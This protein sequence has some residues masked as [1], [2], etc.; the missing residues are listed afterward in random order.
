MVTDKEL[1]KLIKYKLGIF[2]LSKPISEE[3][4]KRV[5]ELSVNN[6][7]FSGQK[8]N[9]DLTQIG[10]L[11]GLQKLDIVSFDIG[12]EEAKSISSL[13]LLEELTINKSSLNV[14]ISMQPLEYLSVTDSQVADLGYL[15]KAEILDLYGLDT[16]D[17]SQLEH[18]KG[19]LKDIG[20]YGGNVKKAGALK[21]MPKL[22][23][24]TFI[25]ATLDDK[26][27]PDE[28][29]DKG[30]NVDYEPDERNIDT[31]FKQ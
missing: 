2:D 25:G 17:L 27:V 23:E 7:S 10:E 4:L 1:L 19:V 11:H 5:Y 20:I 3:D 30:V 26:N 15:P 18:L 31:F 6:L 24:A 12:E 9:I 22:E 14:P 13:N 28:L 29:T 21:D 8:K 16:M